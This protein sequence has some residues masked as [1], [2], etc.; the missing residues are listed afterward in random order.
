[1]AVAIPGLSGGFV[2]GFLLLQGEGMSSGNCPT[3][4]RAAVGCS[5]GQHLGGSTASWN[6]ER[7][8]T[9]GHTDLFSP[10]VYFSYAVE[11]YFFLYARKR[12]VLDATAAYVTSEEFGLRS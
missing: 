6:L 3:G 10:T 1:M 4:W 8:K 11:L 7:G 12:R 2:P 5:Q 9:R